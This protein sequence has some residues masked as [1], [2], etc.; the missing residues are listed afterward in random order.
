MAFPAS[1][2][3][4]QEDGALR[5]AGIRVSFSSVVIAFQEGES[6]ERIA[7]SFPT[8]TLAQVYG[9]AAYYLVN[10]K[11]IHDRIAKV[12]REF[13]RLVPPLSQSNPELYARLM[14][15]RRQMGSMRT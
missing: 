14:A 9:A 6:P 1:P 11:L 15:A 5:I 12:E 13:E 2:Y 4:D 10:K 7:H 3:I 8:V